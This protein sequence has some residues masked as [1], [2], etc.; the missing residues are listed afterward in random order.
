LLKLF[1]RKIKCSFLVKNATNSIEIVG[2]LKM[3]TINEWRRFD[4]INSEYKILKI[5]VKVIALDQIHEST[6]K[7]PFNV[8][9]FGKFI[10]VYAK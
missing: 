4:Q 6:E 9:E 1:A 5:R 7:F 8:I 10:G 2:L 3:L